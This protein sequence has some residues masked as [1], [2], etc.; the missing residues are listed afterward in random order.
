MRNVKQSLPEAS[1]KLVTINDRQASMRM[2]LSFSQISEEDF[3]DKHVFDKLRKK[4]LQEF[5]D[6]FKEDLSPEDRL[7]TLPVKIELVDDYE[8]IKAYTSPF[9]KRSKEKTS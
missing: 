9:G 7:Q 6:I 4:L 5:S 3:E 2:Q 1:P 8:S